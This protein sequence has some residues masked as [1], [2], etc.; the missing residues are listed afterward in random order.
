MTAHSSRRWRLHAL[1]ACA[2]LAT[3][4]AQA[5]SPAGAP[6]AGGVQITG[7]STVMD[8]K[9][10]SVAR[11][12]FDAGA[13][14]FW[15]SHDNGQLL[16]V[17]SGRMWTQKRG[18]AKRELGP[19]DHDYAGPNVVHWHGAT[20]AERLVQVNVGFSGTTKWLEAVSD[21]DYRK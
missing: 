11:R 12:S 21:A 2:G 1:I 3:I 6:Q 10:L 19:G 14:T 7:V 5:Q 4:A 20:P 13:R 9:D 18:Q 16:Y 15:H 8:A 17:E